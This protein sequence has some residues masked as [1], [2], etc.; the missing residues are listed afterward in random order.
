MHVFIVSELLEGE[1]LRAGWAKSTRRVTRLDR[2]V[3]IKV[4]P[5][6]LDAMN[7]TISTCQLL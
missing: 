6:A 2:T 5:E 4:L 1:T 3:A 7:G